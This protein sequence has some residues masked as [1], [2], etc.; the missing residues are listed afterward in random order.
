MLVITIM[1]REGTQD[2]ENRNWN[3]GYLKQRLENTC[4]KMTF[5]RCL[6]KMKTYSICISEGRVFQEE[7]KGN[8]KVFDIR[9]FAVHSR[10]SKIR[11]EGIECTRKT[12]ERKAI[13]KASTGRITLNM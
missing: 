5:S 9:S 2:L 3:K 4:E 7:S 11:W 8:C 10:I 6:S 12:K 1:C 13:Q